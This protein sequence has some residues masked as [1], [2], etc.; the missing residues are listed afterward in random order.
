MPDHDDEDEDFSLADHPGPGGPKAGDPEMNRARDMMHLDV[1]RKA[2][3]KLQQ[4][5]TEQEKNTARDRQA[6][7]Q[8]TPTGLPA[9]APV[10]VAWEAFKKSDRYSELFDDGWTMFLAG[11]AARDSQPKE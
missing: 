8:E 7:R 3:A 2:A 1:T 11:W 10:V 5:L 4:P 9:D 6:M